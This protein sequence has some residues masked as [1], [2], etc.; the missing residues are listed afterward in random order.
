[1]RSSRRYGRPTGT[2][3]Q[4]QSVLIVCV[5][6][7]T[8]RRYFNALKRELGLTSV[9]V[10]PRKVDPGRVVDEACDSSPDHDQCWCVFDTES[11]DN[12]DAVLEAVEKARTRNVYLA[13]SNPAFEY[14]FLLH[15]KD[16]DRPFQNARSVVDELREYLPGYEKNADMYEDLK[17]RTDT[18]I[19]N[20]QKVLDRHRSASNG[21]FPNSSTGVHELVEALRELSKTQGRGR[22]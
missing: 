2:R 16:T 21:E 1:M 19:S 11:L 7:E 10:R 4:K 15:F 6:E 13:V 3:E 12:R 22:N 17:G 14:W 9:T 18:A 8:E 20:A 5:G